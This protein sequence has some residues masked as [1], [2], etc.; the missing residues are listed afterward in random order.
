MFEKI[1][2]IICD[3]LGLAADKVKEESKFID[4]LDY[5]FWK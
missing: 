4:D 3:Q 5:E 2:K 1:Q